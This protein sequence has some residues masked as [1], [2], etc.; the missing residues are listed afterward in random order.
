MTEAEKVT[1][2]AETD[3]GTNRL[4][5]KSQAGTDSNS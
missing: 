5:R 2:R 4:T 1:Y 3:T